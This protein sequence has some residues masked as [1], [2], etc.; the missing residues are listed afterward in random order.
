MA[1]R[2]LVSLTSV[3]VLPH[4]LGPKSTTMGVSSSAMVTVILLGSLTSSNVMLLLVT[5]GP[6]D[7]A[8][9]PLSFTVISSFVP[10]CPAA[11]RVLSSFWFWK[12]KSILAM[13]V[14]F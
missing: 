1:L 9:V 13:I 7:V 10:F 2:Y 14:L 12:P 11:S 3:I 5:D 8:D 6:L 4:D